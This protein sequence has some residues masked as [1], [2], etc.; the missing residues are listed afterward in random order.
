METKKILV[1]SDESSVVQ[2][3]SAKL[4]NNG[5]EVVT[6]NN[7]DEAF[8][9]C[10]QQKPEFVIADYQLPNISGVELAEDIRKKSGLTDISFIL[11]TTKETELDEKQMEKAGITCCLSKPF[12][13]KEILNRIENIL[14]SATTK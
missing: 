12:S 5:F 3:I 1:A 9:L 10:C 14:A 11:L 4:R 6:A 7:G 8:I 13:P 2:I